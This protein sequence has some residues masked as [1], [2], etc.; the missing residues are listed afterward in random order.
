MIMP[1]QKY[2]QLTDGE[3]AILQHVRQRH[4]RCWKKVVRHEWM[5]GRASPL[6]QSLR[7]T[8][9]PRWLA[10]FD[11]SEALALE[12]AAHPAG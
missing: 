8:H 12:A 6:M 11:L 5:S 10:K 1:S 9:G 4:G 7:N 2:R 3:L